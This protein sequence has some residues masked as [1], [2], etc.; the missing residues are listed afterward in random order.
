MKTTT[1]RVQDATQ[2]ARRRYRL[3][4]RGT[5]S[6]QRKTGC[7][8]VLLVVRG[9]WKIL[10]LCPHRIRPRTSTSCY[11][12]SQNK[13]A[14]KGTDGSTGFVNETQSTVD[15]GSLKRDDESQS[16]RAAFKC[17]RCL[18]VA[19][20]NQSWASLVFVLLM[21]GE[22]RKKGGAVGVVPRVHDQ[23]YS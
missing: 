13:P 1:D 11:F 10:D 3:S 7:C 12:R 21:G 16:P 6:S 4:R 20:S 2:M 19:T 17:P 9:V 22:E 23:C 8:E 18:Q 5:Q 14:S 15:T